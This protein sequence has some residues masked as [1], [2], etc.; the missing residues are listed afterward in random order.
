MGFGEGHKPRFE[1]LKGGKKRSLNTEFF[2]P[3]GED[4]TLHKALKTG[5]SLGVVEEGDGVGKIVEEK[6]GPDL[7]E[8]G[9][10]GSLARC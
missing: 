1:E 8:P 2:L 5:F 7:K 6:D 10:R 4:S 3:V 9:F